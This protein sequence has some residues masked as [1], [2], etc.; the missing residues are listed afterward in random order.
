MCRDRSPGNEYLSSLAVSLPL[1]VDTTDDER[2]RVA[3]AI[4]DA[5]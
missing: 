4:V 2:N 3:A 5:T 1:A